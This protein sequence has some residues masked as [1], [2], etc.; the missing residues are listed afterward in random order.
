MA[1]RGGMIGH[2]AGQALTG[3]APGFIAATVAWPAPGHAPDHH[4]N[5]RPGG[6]FT[7]GVL[8]WDNFANVNFAKPP[9]PHQAARTKKKA[10]SAWLPAQ[11]VRRRNMVWRRR[12]REG[13]DQA[14]HPAKLVKTY[15]L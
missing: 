10:G 12:G 3:Q 11:V 5:L 13:E 15:M 4:S 1:Q 6:G 9:P 8:R 7:Y 2:E 14:P